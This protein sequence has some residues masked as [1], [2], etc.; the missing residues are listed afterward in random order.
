MRVSRWL[1]I[2]NKRFREVK[3]LNLPVFQT[4][5]SR[6]GAGGRWNRKWLEIQWTRPAIQN[7][8]ALLWPDNC[9]FHFGEA[10]PRERCSVPSWERISD[11]ADC[12]FTTRRWRCSETP[13]RNAEV[14]CKSAGIRIDS[15]VLRPRYLIVFR[16][17]TRCSS[18]T[19]PNSWKLCV[20]EFLFYGRM[21]DR[22]RFSQIDFVFR[23][24]TNEEDWKWV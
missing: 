13:L 21:K 22:F 23:G 14:A 2:T 4:L 1:I 10:K 19:Y 11:R 6:T 12:T 15:S 17:A 24:S 18:H 20:V 7:K 9:K 3:E 8:A 5:S 16:T